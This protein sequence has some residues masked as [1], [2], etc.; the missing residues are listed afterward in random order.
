MAPSDQMMLNRG[1]VQQAF[2]D[3][4]FTPPDTVTAPINQADCSFIEREGTGYRLH[5]VLSEVL[6]IMLM[7]LSLKPDH[8]RRYTDVA[9]LL[10]K[11]GGVGGKSIVEKAGWQSD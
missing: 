1:P 8:L 6:Y 7:G 10:I 9:R 3:N 11:Y 2:H 4:G 5:R